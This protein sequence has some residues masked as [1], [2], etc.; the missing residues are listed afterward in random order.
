MAPGI[1]PDIRYCSQCGA[2]APVEQLARFG[3]TLVCPNC[4]DI[5]LQKL[6]EGVSPFQQTFQYAGF[7]IRFVAVLIDG[8][9]LGVVG[10]GI[11]FAMLG[12]AFGPMARIRPDTPPDQVMSAML[13][14]LGL[15]GLSVV[16]NTAIAACYEAFFI[17]RVGATPGKMTLSLKVIRPNGAPISLGRAF[18]RYFAK[19]LSSL[20]FCI[21]YIIAGFDSQK[22]AMHDMIC[23]TRVI[24][25]ANTASVNP[26][27]QPV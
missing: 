2:P 12:S 24:K 22:K 17:S 8:I 14:M 20:T 4:K 15:L 23:D 6:R 7:W 5:Y 18:G 1:N 3:D 9:I 11:Q 13:P 21:G 10:S 27:V 26:Y 16:I 19:M 25:T